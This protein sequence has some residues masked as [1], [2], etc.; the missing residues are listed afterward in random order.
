MSEPAPAAVLAAL[1]G[2]RVVGGPVRDALAGVAVHDVDVAAPMPPEEI[3]RRLSAAGLKV[4]ETGLAHGTL[5]AVLGGVPVEVTA[6]RRDVATDGRH[7]EVA[8]TTD[9]REDAARRDFTINAMSLDAGGQLWDYFGGREDLEAGRVRFVGDPATRLRE[10]Y[11]R[12]LRFFRFWA[13]YGRG[14]ADAAALA[15]IRAAVPGLA[16]RIAPE[17]IWMELKRLLAAPDPVEALALMRECGLLAAVL[18]EAGGFV[19]LGRLVARG[20]PAEPLLRLAALLP[21]ADPV[22]ALAR[23]LRLSNEEREAL[24]H[25]AALSVPAALSVSDK[26]ALRAWL[27][28]RPKE[29]AAGELW[30][31]EARDGQDRAALRDAVGA[32][33]RPVFPLLG[34]DLLELGVAPGPAMGR[35]LSELR[36]WWIAGGA[37]ADRDACLREAQARIVDGAAYGPAAPTDPPGQHPAK[38]PPRGT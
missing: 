6:L 10:D 4:F 34:R 3:A 35:L 9:W 15:A 37:G 11:L 21:S 31:A 23:R 14:A 2:S 1:P 20:A 30:L 24:W 19:P 8:W 13:R 5:T 17:R 25:F 29:Q 33:E 18:P 26:S 27:A 28:E 38:D 16:A 7:A 12:A 32:M 36:G 22:P